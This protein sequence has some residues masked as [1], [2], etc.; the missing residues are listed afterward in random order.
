MK[1]VFLF[2][3]PLALLVSGCT[4]ETIEQASPTEVFK[5]T[6]QNEFGGAPDSFFCQKGFK[7]TAEKLPVLEKNNGSHYDEETGTDVEDYIYSDGWMFEDGRVVKSGDT[8]NGNITLYCRWSAIPVKV[9]WKIKD[10]DAAIFHDDYT[11][12]LQTALEQLNNTKN[13]LDRYVLLDEDKLAPLV[14]EDY[15]FVGWYID[16]V[17]IEPDTV[18]L[19]K[20]TVFYGKWSRIPAGKKTV[21][22]HP[23]Y[24]KTMNE[25]LPLFD[26]DFLNTTV[27]GQNYITFGDIIRFHKGRAPGMPDHLYDAENQVEFFYKDNDFYVNAYYYKDEKNN[28]SVPGYGAPNLIFEYGIETEAFDLDDWKKNFYKCNDVKLTGQGYPVLFKST[29]W[30]TEP[31]GSGS[32]V[33]DIEI[34]SFL[35][36]EIHLYAIWSDEIQFGFGTCDS[37]VNFFLFDHSTGTYGN[38]A[39][40]Y[41]ALTWNKK[42]PPSSSDILNIESSLRKTFLGEEAWYSFISFDNYSADGEMINDSRITSRIAT[43]EKTKSNCVNDCT[44]QRLTPEITMTVEP[45]KI[46]DPDKGDYYYYANPYIILCESG[47]YEVYYQRYYDHHGVGSDDHKPFFVTDF[48][49]AP[50]YYSAGKAVINETGYAPVNSVLTFDIYPDCFKRYRIKINTIAYLRNIMSQ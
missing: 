22:Y 38:T 25:I 46:Y 27:P 16:D 36:E 47:I 3:I 44:F 19:D 34:D 12:Q 31:D 32:G 37:Q 43:I 35:T 17:K 30:N 41:Y 48:E 18:G 49:Y 23:N 45:E 10:N 24:N 39:P 29:G 1:K 15:E 9:T 33:Q 4:V 42:T 2:L 7:L 20:N 5:V 13:K 14:I 11:V 50:Y 40:R 8:V 26:P 6:Y 28:V 21:V